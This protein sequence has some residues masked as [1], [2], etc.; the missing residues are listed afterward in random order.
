MYTC[1]YIC[2]HA[3]LVAN[4]PVNHTCLLVCLRVSV[5]LCVCDRAPNC[6]MSFTVCANSRRLFLGFAPCHLLDAPA[7]SRSHYY[8]AADA[9]APSTAIPPHVCTADSRRHAL[10]QY[11]FKKKSIGK[12]G[13]FWICTGLNSRSRFPFRLPI[14]EGHACGNPLYANIR[15][16]GHVLELVRGGNVYVIWNK[17]LICN[18]E[19]EVLKICNVCTM[20]C[21]WNV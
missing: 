21:I 18:M 15:T 3:T 10:L 4:R 17:K 14:Q 16:Y 13:K 20:N 9:A 7:C 1:I 19:H 11:K 5:C 2:I 12:P 8:A 6:D